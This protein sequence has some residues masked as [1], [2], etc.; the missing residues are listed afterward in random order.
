MSNL[1]ISPLYY[2]DIFI[3]FLTFFQVL[4]KSLHLTKDSLA[5]SV[6]LIN[7]HKPSLFINV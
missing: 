2:L 6:Y 3:G 1:S 5:Y 7:H 4:L